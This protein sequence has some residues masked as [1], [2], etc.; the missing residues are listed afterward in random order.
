[1]SETFF[2]AHTSCVLLLLFDQV[3]I[4]ILCESCNVY[5]K[6]N[7]DKKFRFSFLDKKKSKK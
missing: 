5:G 4:M 6:K 7:L 1:M 3:I 2:V